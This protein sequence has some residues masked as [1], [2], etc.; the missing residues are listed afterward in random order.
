M[1]R[2]REYS[3]V[4][5]LNAFL[6]RTNQ[7]NVFATQDTKATGRFALVSNFILGPSL[8]RVK[9]FTFVNLYFVFFS[10]KIEHYTHIETSS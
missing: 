4:R 10:V 6:P 9:P 7:E 2:V 8:Q 3:A 1:A 5:M